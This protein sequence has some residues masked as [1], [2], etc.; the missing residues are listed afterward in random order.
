MNQNTSNE[1]KETCTKQF[2]FLK[3]Y[4]LNN[5]AIG[6]KDDLIFNGNSA[7]AKDYFTNASKKQKLGPEVHQANNSSSSNIA[8]VNL[9]TS[10]VFGSTYEM[11]TKTKESGL[12]IL[13]RAAAAAFESTDSENCSNATLS[14]DAIESVQTS[15]EIIDENEASD[16]EA[17]DISDNNNEIM[18]IVTFSP[19]KPQ[20]QAMTTESRLEYLCRVPSLIQVATNSSNLEMLQ[21]ILDETVTED[22]LHKFTFMDPCR[23]RDKWY[24]QIAAVL[25]S[26]PDYYIA[27]TSPMLFRR[28]ICMKQYNYGTMGVLTGINNSPTTDY[29]WNPFK[30]VPFEKMDERMKANKIL[31]DKCMSEGKLVRFVQRSILFFM[32]NEE[33]THIEQRVAYC[34]SLELFEANVEDFFKN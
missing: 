12:D 14:D 21:Y 17:S 32:L 24:L 25:N 27:N 2:L 7:A 31:Y 20:Y 28:C 29:L 6:K 23:G 4:F 33:M 26:V 16:V 3:K 34:E 1:D 10:A 19:R 5:N 8:H 11:S 22:C 30:A 18:P 13:Y 15:N 9:R